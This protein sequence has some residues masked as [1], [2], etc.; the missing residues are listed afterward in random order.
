LS[1]QS[2][3]LKDL[4]SKVN[5]DIVGDPNLIIRSI[6]TLQNASSGCISF[7]SN[8]KYKKFLSNTSASAVIVNRENA[9]ELRL[10]VL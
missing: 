1:G 3:S 9:V 4:A 5:G 8:S 2:Y 7:L 6:A 10:L